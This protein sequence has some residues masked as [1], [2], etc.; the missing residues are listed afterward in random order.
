M[1]EILYGKPVAAAI[2]NEVGAGVES[3]GKRGIQPCLSIIRMGQDQSAES[4]E[5]S[6]VSRFQKVGIAV[7][8][9]AVSQNAD[10]EALTEIIQK[11]NLDESVHGCM[12]LR[13]L[14]Q[15][16]DEF[17]VLEKLEPAKDVDCAGRMSLG[18]VFSGSGD[19]F[20]PCTAEACMNMLDYY[21]VPLRGA[22][23]AVIGRSLVVGRPLAMMLQ[24]R[25]A[26]VT[27][28]HSKTPDAAKICREQDIVI[29]AAGK[30][31]LV[32]ESYTNCRQIVLDVG[33]DSDKDG[34]ICGDVDFERVRDAVAAISPVPRGVGSVTTAVLAR[35]VVAAAQK[36]MKKTEE[37]S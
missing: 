14:S 2:W 25:D 36:S 15:H 22:R 7:K 26:T 17:R 12:I 31:R 4:Y 23:V 9:S 30:L 32:D 28:C 21:N 11:V 37:N 33:I 18:G 27:M 6:I 20:C 13:P 24:Q 35:H 19:Y 16:I 10:E 5:N 3:L 34:N 8:C 1:G 29:S